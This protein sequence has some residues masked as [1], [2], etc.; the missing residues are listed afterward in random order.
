MTYS[1]L[2]D[3]HGTSQVNLRNATVIFYFLIEKLFTIC[4]D[5]QPWQ[6]AAEG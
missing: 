6:V 4:L 1:E 3:G 2:K 5:Q